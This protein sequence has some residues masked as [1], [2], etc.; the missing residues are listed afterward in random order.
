MT[1]PTRHPDYLRRAC[2]GADPDSFCL[3]DGERWETAQHR[4]E[5]AARSLCRRCPVLEV[6]RA[7][8][9]GSEWGL[10]GGVF[11]RRDHGVASSVDLLKEQT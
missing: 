6:C 8:G 9:V 11:H 5:Y 3:K 2:N 10:W 4:I 1:T 7:A